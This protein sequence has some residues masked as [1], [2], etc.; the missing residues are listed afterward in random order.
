M[1]RTGLARAAALLLALVMMFTTLT[2]CGD[3]SQDPNGEK[4]TP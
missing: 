1:K 3:K 4:R 2:A